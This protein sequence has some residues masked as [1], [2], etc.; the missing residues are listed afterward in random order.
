MLNDDTEC[1]SNPTVS[2]TTFYI[3]V[4]FDFLDLTYLMNL[5][6]KIESNG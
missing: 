5:T 2:I 1:R 4:R 6:A 3:Y